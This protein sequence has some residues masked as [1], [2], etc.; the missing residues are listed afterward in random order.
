MFVLIYELK[1]IGTICESFKRTAFHEI[2][3]ALIYGSIVVFMDVDAHGFMV[4]DQLILDVYSILTGVDYRNKSKPLRNWYRNHEFFRRIRLH[5][6]EILIG[7]PRGSPH[8]LLKCLF[9][10]LLL[11]MFLIL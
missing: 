4:I 1:S 6:E 5:I 8:V 3:R 7:K 2:E 10:S 11:I 9:N